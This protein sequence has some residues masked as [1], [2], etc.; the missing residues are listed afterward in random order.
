MIRTLPTTD[1]YFL[2][3]C[4]ASVGRWW[5]PG[6]VQRLGANS[7]RAGN[8]HVLIRRDE[9][10][11]MD[12]ALAGS[13]PLI[14]VIDDDID[15]AAR[16]PGLPASYRARLAEFADRYQSRLLQRAE[17][18]LTSSDM[19]AAKFRADERVRG[20]VIRIDPFW[21]RPFADQAHFP[22]SPD[23]RLDLVHLGT[24]SHG[25]GLA[26]ITPAVLAVLERFPSAHFTFIAVPGQHGDLEAHPRAHRLNVMSWPRYRRWLPR[27]RFHLALYP[28]EPTPFDQAR[29]A[30][31]IFE[32]AI[33]G[34]VGVYPR[35]WPPAAMVA[36]GCVLAPED[37][38][39]WTQCLIE[40][41]ER[42]LTLATLGEAARTLL[43]KDH[44]GTA[45]R[46]IWANLLNLDT[47]GQ[48]LR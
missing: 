18:I 6:P 32:H 17:T 19:L 4:R 12:R 42:R 35:D 27:Q 14:Y 11:L 40:T 41:M 9:P 24:A 13:D 44:H 8:R 7:F 1:L 26:R 48:A 2:N 3:S 15:G 43:E 45:Q 20:T 30:N 23:A 39:T 37:A 38:T 31:K 33:V 21:A 29:S 47:R 28:L 46:R 16:S 36:G 5:R 22:G 34:A 10:A 25:G